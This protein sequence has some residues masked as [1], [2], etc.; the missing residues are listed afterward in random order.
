MSTRFE[1]GEEGG[2]VPR[3]EE[4]KKKKE[5]EGERCHRRRA[6]LYSLIATVT[7]KGI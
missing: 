5:R 2:S 4:R 7:G 6:S 1:R 3:G